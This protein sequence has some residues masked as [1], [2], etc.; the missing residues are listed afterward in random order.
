M[1]LGS[2]QPRKTVLSLFM[3]WFFLLISADAGTSDAGTLM[4]FP[5]L[6][7]YTVCRTSQRAASY[8]IRDQDGEVLA[9]ISAILEFKSINVP[10]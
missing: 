5:I 10:S 3:S 7:V 4:E 1:L 2:P 8:S 6:L 9:A